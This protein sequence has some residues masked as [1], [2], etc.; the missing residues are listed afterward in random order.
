MKAKY[1][2]HSLT[3]ALIGLVAAGMATSCSETID[4]PEK[5]VG[6]GVT[7]MSMDWNGAMTDFTG[8]DVDG[9]RAEAAWTW[10]NGN[11][12]LI[13]DNDQSHTPIGRAVYDTNT[14]AWTFEARKTGLTEGTCVA[15]FTPNVIDFNTSTGYI[16]V[17]NRSP[18]FRGEGQ[19]KVTD[20]GIFRMSCVL[21]PA[22]ARIHYTSDT[23]SDF[24]I[25]YASG[26][27]RLEIGDFF[28][29]PTSSASISAS[30]WTR[31]T[32]GN[33][34]TSPYI[35]VISELVPRVKIGDTVYRYR[36]DGRDP[37][38]GKSIRMALGGT[39]GSD[40]T[41]E[42]A[43]Y[44]HHSSSMS[45]KNIYGST[46]HTLMSQT[47]ESAIGFYMT[48]DY[49]WTPYSGSLTQTESNPYPFVLTMNINDESTQEALCEITGTDG[50][51]W[52]YI[53]RFNQTKVG[54][55]KVAPSGG[56]DVYVTITSFKISNF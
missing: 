6:S 19:Y 11:T 40:N 54:N 35:Y 16:A 24:E 2:R 28:T 36:A 20:D 30:E 45:R 44:V 9:S 32:A 31:N 39:F 3:A 42:S 27:Y 37:E 48:V 52:S 1:I 23:A 21:N 15:Y 14:G 51:E 17:D 29:D 10:M 5:P 38:A 55:V 50:I 8:S 33:G 18:I 25:N 49:S 43:P 41:W 26:V 4:A 47:L 53:L 13:Y 34:Y 22:C 46:T 12:V 7:T 56:N